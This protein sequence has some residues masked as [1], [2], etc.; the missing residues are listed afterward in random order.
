MSEFTH[1]DIWPECAICG[2]PVEW[3]ESFPDDYRGVIVITVKCHGDSETTLLKERDLCDLE[4]VE[5]GQAF[6]KK[7]LPEVTDG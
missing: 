7:R 3:M 6:T 1:Q 2:K 4:G 5:P